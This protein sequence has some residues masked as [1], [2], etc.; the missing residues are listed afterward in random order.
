MYCKR[1]KWGQEK[2]WVTS[3][4]IIELNDYYNYIIKEEIDGDDTQCR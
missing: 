3:D 1:S 2:E 4:D